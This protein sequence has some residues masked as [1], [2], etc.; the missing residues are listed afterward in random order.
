MNTPPDRLPPRIVLDTNVCLD[1]FLF[2]DVR[3]APLREALRCGAAVAVTDVLCRD[4]WCRVLSYAALGLDTGQQAEAAVEF[5]RWVALLD[6]FPLP[7]EPPR[8]EPPLPRCRDPDDQK[9]LELARRCRAR[10]LLSRDAHLLAVGRRTA[11]EGGF[12]ILTPQAWAERLP[13]PN[14]GERAG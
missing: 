10:W 3:A 1:L 2:D 6:A 14:E 4:E 5:D 7:D 8:Q 9:F 11:H 12:E 13:S